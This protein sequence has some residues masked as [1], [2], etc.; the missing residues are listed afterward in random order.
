MKALKILGMVLCLSGCIYAGEFSVLPWRDDVVAGLS[1][2][3]I[4]YLDRQSE[5]LLKTEV[6][7]E[8]SFKA[9]KLLTAFKGY[10]IV[11]TKSYSK[12]YYVQESLVA[13][14]SAQLI[15]GYAPASVE[16]G[17]KYDII[18]QVDI[19][20]KIYYVLASGKPTYVFLA[21]ENYVLQDHIA[22][23]R[24]DKL[25]MIDGKFV[26]VPENFK[27][28]PITKSRIVQSD[29]VTGFE[30]KYQGVKSGMMV[31]SLLEYD[32]GGQTG[33]FIN[34]TFENKPG[35]IEIAGIR[36][37]VF[38]ADDSKLEYMIIVK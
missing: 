8:S 2:Y 5:K 9:N 37:K 29:M 23:I 21:D 10:T 19:D 34:Y 24:D 4:E 33:E 18:G 25:V 17:K 11:D 6:L 12:N 28:E 31:F 20:D 27:F 1:G 22:T 26:I 16:G 36:I 13:P 7:Q 35:V 32:A 38:Y 30:I 14:E 15:S 3:Q